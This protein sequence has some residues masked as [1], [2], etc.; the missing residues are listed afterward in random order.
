MDAYLFLDPSRCLSDRGDKCV[1]ETGGGGEGG[2]LPLVHAFYNTWAGGVCCC[3]CFEVV[4]EV[5]LDSLFW[6]SSTRAMGFRRE[7]KRVS[8]PVDL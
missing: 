5:K 7:K 3:V 1:V 6:L 2:V 4:V 8:T